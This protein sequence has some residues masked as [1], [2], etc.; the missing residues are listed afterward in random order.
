MFN[1]PI[2]AILSLLLC[3]TAYVYWPQESGKKSGARQGKPTLVKAQDANV[4]LF[5]DEISALGTAQAN[6]SVTLTAQSTDRVKSIYFDDGQSVQKGQR[7]LALEHGEEQALIQELEVNL[8]EQKRQLARLKNLRKNSATAESS[9]DMQ[10]SLMEATQAK[11]DVAKI[12][13]SEKFINAPFSGQLGLRQVSPGQL[14]TNNTEITS[15]DD[16]SKIKVEFQLPE[17]Y[18]NQVA[19]GQSVAATNVAYD[20]PFHG[21]VLAI[22][23]RVD[24]VS[25]AFA[26]RAIFDNSDR[27][28]RP[29]MLLQ[30]KVETQAADALVIPESAIIPINQKQYVYQI[31]EQKVQRVEVTIGRRQPGL[32][33]ILSGLQQGDQV[34]TEGVVKVRPGSL[35]TTQAATQVAGN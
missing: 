11:L 18:L 3:M 33:E 14:L 31:I 9:I 19:V 16:V 7:L 2:L 24:R 17:K 20:L 28:L 35:V 13:L 27:K 8:A 10:S 1:K 29:G 15:L 32:V 12:R 23:S 30:L 6:E 34:V 5:K 25:R 21:Q 26:V 4:I 22:S